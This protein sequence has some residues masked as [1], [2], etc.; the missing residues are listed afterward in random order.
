M[1]RRSAG[2]GSKGARFYDWAWRDDVCTE[3]QQAHTA[4]VGRHEQAI[5]AQQQA[6]RAAA[7]AVVAA[8]EHLRLPCSDGGNTAGSSRASGEPCSPRRSA[9]GTTRTLIWPPPSP[10]PSRWPQPTRTVPTTPLRSRLTRY[11]QRPP[12]CNTPGRSSHVLDDVAPE[13]R[14]TL[15]D[16]AWLSDPQHRELAAPWCNHDGWAKLPYFGSSPGNCP[17]DRCGPITFRR[18]TPLR[19]SYIGDTAGVPSLSSALCARGAILT[20]AGTA[21]KVD[22]CLATML[23][24]CRCTE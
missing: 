16:D 6:D 22:L 9:A 1:A 8:G 20:H 18:P 10:P 14:A 23:A 19:Q 4:A 11:R 13:L 2:A 5:V 7:A 15:P 21:A 17:Y 12:R 3:L 24:P